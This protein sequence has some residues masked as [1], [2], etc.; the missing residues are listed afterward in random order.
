MLLPV[1][2]MVE[3]MGQVLVMMLEREFQLL[4]PLPITP[5]EPVLLRGREPVLLRGRE[6]V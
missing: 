6:P 4:L 3:G 1:Q 5:Q 2:V